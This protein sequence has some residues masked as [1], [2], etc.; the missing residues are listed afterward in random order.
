MA[1]CDFVRQIY[2]LCTSAKPMKK[3]RDI[4][5]VIISILLIGFLIALTLKVIYIVPNPKFLDIDFVTNSN[6]IQS[7]AALIGSILTFLSI[8]YVVYTIVQQRELFEKERKVELE[9]KE[10]DL[11]DRITLI[12]TLVAD[13]IEHILKSGVEIKNFYETEFKVS[14]SRKF[15]AILC[16][17]QFY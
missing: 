4:S 8:I 2:E 15:I 17:Q 11:L 10:S 13:L 14:A 12:D 1:L 7:Y 5:I 6:V 16:Q 3:I 9:N